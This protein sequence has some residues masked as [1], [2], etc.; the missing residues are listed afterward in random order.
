MNFQIKILVRYRS[1]SS[2]KYELYALRGDLSLALPKNIILKPISNVMIWWVEIL[3]S[4]TA[5]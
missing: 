4:R 2:I 5:E 1:V 3:Y